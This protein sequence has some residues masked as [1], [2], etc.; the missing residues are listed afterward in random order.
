MSQV[1]KYP[2]SIEFEGEFLTTSG[3]KEADYKVILGKDTECQTTL[4][5]T[6]SLTCKPPP[7]QPQP[8]PGVTKIHNQKTVPHVEVTLI[9]SC[10]RVVL[11]EFWQALLL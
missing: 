3:L 8:D 1:Y 9:V 7:Q 10:L 2:E 4:L 6:N 5:T 11:M